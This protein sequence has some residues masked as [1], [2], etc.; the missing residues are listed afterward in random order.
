MYCSGPARIIHVVVELE[1]RPLQ[2][3]KRY[4]M[5]VYTRFNPLH[6]GRVKNNITHMYRKYSIYIC[7]RVCVRV[8]ICFYV[9]V[10][11]VRVCGVTPVEYVLLQVK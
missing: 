5:R 1:R 3:P 9:S 8:R 7:L 6:G 10:S 11:D 4:R 2:K